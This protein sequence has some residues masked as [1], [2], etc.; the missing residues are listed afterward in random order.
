MGV[1]IP[2]S[3]RSDDA[4]LGPL[5][6]YSA[7]RSEI[8]HLMD[9]QWKV[10]AFLITTSGAVFGFAFTSASRIPLLL[11]IP[12][13]S[14]IL[15]SRWVGCSQ[16]IERVALYIRTELDPQVPG[17]IGYEKWLRRTP[18]EPLGFRRMIRYAQA[19]PM[20]IIFPA[21]AVLALGCVAWWFLHSGRTWSDPA[22]APGL[23]AWTLGLVLTLLSLR[24]LWL[25]A[26]RRTVTDYLHWKPGAG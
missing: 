7:L 8:I 18:D 10:T 20:G 19:S 21:L 5:A 2:F 13:S 1:R 6:E 17:G 16:L 12:F 26:N 4:H 11:I 14:N 24:L 23:A 25:A 3:R 22:I 9:Q 15:A